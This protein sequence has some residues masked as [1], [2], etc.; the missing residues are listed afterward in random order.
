MIKA[1]EYNQTQIDP[2]YLPFFKQS[3]TY[4]IGLYQQGSPAFPDREYTF[5]IEV[6]NSNH[7]RYESNP[8]Y[9]GL[10][11]HYVSP[12]K[13]FY[14]PSQSKEYVMDR[15]VEDYGNYH[16]VKKSDVKIFEHV[17]NVPGSEAINGGGY[18]MVER[19]TARTGPHPVYNK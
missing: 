5:V 11:L 18:K 8:V 15:A 14:T 12:D 10:E 7:Y 19:L 9:H 17:D 6:K 1:S 2:D 13:E 4:C 3:V 16:G